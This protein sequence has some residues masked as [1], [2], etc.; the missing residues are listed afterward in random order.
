MILDEKDVDDE[1]GY[2]DDDFSPQYSISQRL[3]GEESVMM[4]MTKN[5][6]E[7]D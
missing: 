5:V 1:I 2:N 3:F 7:N 4:M 6:D